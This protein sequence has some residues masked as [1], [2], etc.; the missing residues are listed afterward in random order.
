M[1]ANNISSS[2]LQSVQQSSNTQVEAPKSGVTETTSS[3][4]YL[5]KLAKS[6]NL[7][8]AFSDVVHTVSEYSNT[9]DNSTLQNILG[10]LSNLE[11]LDPKT[12]EKTLF[13]FQ[14]GSDVQNA[15]AKLRIV[16]AQE[17]TNES[18]N[19]KPGACVIDNPKNYNPDEITNLTQG[20]VILEEHPESQDKNQNIKQ[21]ANIIN[22]SENYN[23]NEITDLKRG[24]NILEDHSK[25]EN[26][27]EA[28][29]TETLQKNHEKY[30]KEDL[31][32]MFV[33]V[34]D[35]QHM[36]GEGSYGKVYANEKF[37]FKVMD[38]EAAVDEIDAN[39]N[40]S[41]GKEGFQTNPEV[42]Y[43]ESEGF[44]TQYYDSIKTNDNRSILV[45][46]RIKGKD[47]CDVINLSRQQ[48]SKDE[49]FD[50]GVAMCSQM[51]AGIAALHE[52]GNVNRDIKPENTMVSLRD[53][54]NAAEDTVSVK[55]I[56]QGTAVN[57]KEP[58]HEHGLV[59]T[60]I[61]M[62]PECFRD[63]K[64]TPA[65]DI[66][67]FGISLIT[68]FATN[69]FVEIAKL[70][71]NGDRKFL[72]K[73]REIINNLQAEDITGGSKEAKQF[74][75]DLIKSCCAKDPSKRP[76][77][78]QANYCLQILQ[79]AMSP[80]VT[81][82]KFADVLKDAQGWR[83]KSVPLAL[84]EMLAID[85]REAQEKGCAAILALGHNDPSYQAT[86]SYGLALLRSENTTDFKEWGQKN[87]NV[88]KDLKGRIFTKT[89]ED[90]RYETKTVKT[91]NKNGEET[92]KSYHVLVRDIRV[93]KREKKAIDDLDAQISRQSQ[94]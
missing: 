77:A 48:L 75:A 27:P 46:E 81:P 85:N 35:E 93:T 3:F 28:S 65:Q 20:V 50:I 10:K 63:A 36:I 61:Y 7:Q 33:D 30:T 17:E 41:K 24:I 68:N 5:D 79:S 71:D 21:G 78:A 67:S 12:L 89:E 11:I 8:S 23:P 84:R 26:P 14:L 52:S 19:A 25:A 2:Q 73:R 6:T 92:E 39:Q 59:G 15:L 87:P 56:D 47:M 91:K 34:Y 38:H 70:I 66:Y 82:P 51:A 55:L 74:I 40:I 42:I 90:N 32:R 1:S 53:P 62:A 31:Q 16:L 64:P 57:L 49:K 60:P 83:P 80:G 45:F 9:I 22:G 72:S 58:E 88:L 69:K 43:R 44:L 86:P 94:S 13:N 54:K 4:S 29:K 76:T 18:Q 37:V